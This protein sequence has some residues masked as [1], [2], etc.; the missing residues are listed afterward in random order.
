MTEK[1]RLYPPTQVATSL[2]AE[3]FTF[4]LPRRPTPAVDNDCSTSATIR[5][6]SNNDNIAGPDDEDVVCKTIDGDDGWV[7]SAEERRR[8]SKKRVLSAAA[9]AANRDIG[10]RRRRGDGDEDNDSMAK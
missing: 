3:K 1:K 9:T 4:R 6:N 2:L 10:K 5:I 7:L 8:R